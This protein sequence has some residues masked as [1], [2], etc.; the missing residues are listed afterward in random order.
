M[1]NVGGD[2]LPLSAAQ[3]GIWFGCQ[4]DPGGKRYRIAEYFDIRGPVDPV[5]FDAA[6][7][8]VVG[9]T[10]ALRVRF[11]EE[12]D[13]PRQ[14][15]GHVETTAVELVD[16]SHAAGPRGRG[17]GTDARRPRPAARADPRPSA[18]RA[19]VQAGPGPLLLVLPV[20][21]R[22]PGRLQRGH[23]GAAGRR[24]VLG[25]RHRRAGRPAG[26]PP[27]ARPPRR[28]S[29]LSCVR[30]LPPRPGVLGV[31][32]GRPGGARDVGRPGVR[33]RR[34]TGAFLGTARHGRTAAGS[35]SPPGG[36]CPPS[37]SRP[38]PPI[39]TG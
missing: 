13:G 21:P 17:A 29:R 19:P 16:V 6:W 10:E 30:R 4:L 3:R 15:V 23:G 27:A 1:S 5:V 34:R 25:P 31:P 39:C 2:T 24:G 22:H 38:W 20:P 35:P 12:A 18:H 9:E 8:Q 37:C 26:P 11:V 14:Y 7:R 28:G 33:R 32:V 36:H